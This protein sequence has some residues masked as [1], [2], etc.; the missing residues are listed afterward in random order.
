MIMVC[1]ECKAMMF[2]HLDCW[3]GFKADEKELIRE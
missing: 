3:C 1:P 2:V